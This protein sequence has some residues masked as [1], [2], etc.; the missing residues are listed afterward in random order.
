M[1]V[2]IPL[3][4][5]CLAMT[6][7][8]VAKGI[9]E[10]FFLKLAVSSDWAFKHWLAAQTRSRKSD[11]QICLSKRGSRSQRHGTSVQ[12]FAVL[13]KA[14]GQTWWI[15]RRG[16]QRT[17]YCNA[18]FP[19]PNKFTSVTALPVQVWPALVQ[20]LHPGLSSRCTIDPFPTLTLV[21]ILQYHWHDSDWRASRSIARL[22]G[23]A[24]TSVQAVVSRVRRAVRIC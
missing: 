13:H 17:Q 5:V 14:R 9:N 1:R 11:V 4:G 12:G 6:Y 23:F 20:S 22:T 16:A 3:T 21:S 19:S 8:V 15:L 18:T 24:A 7:P 2:G 10:D